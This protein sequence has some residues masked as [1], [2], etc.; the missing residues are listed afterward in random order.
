[1][2]NG[3]KPNMAVRPMTTRAIRRCS[4]RFASDIFFSDSYPEPKADIRSAQARVRFGPTA[5][6][7]TEMSPRRLLLP[8]L[9]PLYYAP[10]LAAR[11]KA[12]HAD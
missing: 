6:I 3:S 9:D 2:L 7:A 1:M 8:T 12:S 10:G 11:L 5:D 4:S